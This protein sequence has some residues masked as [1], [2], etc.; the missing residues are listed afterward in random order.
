[1]DA[2]LVAQLAALIQNQNQRANTLHSMPMCCDLNTMCSMGAYKPPVSNSIPETTSSLE[3]YPCS[4]RPPPGLE[5]VMPGPRKGAGPKARQISKSSMSTASSEVEQMDDHEDLESNASGAEGIPAAIPGD[6]S[7]IARSWDSALRELLH[8]VPRLARDA[9]GAPLLTQ[10]INS[11]DMQGLTLLVASLRPQLADLSCDAAGS[12]VVQQIFRSCCELPALRIQ[13]VEGLQGSIQKLTKDKNG[14]LVIQEALESATWEMQMPIMTELNGKVFYCSRHMHGNFV[15]QKVIQML[16]PNSLGF[17]IYELKENAVA[18]ALHIYACRVLQ[19][20]IECCGAATSDLVDIL[21]QPG[22]QLQ[23][24]V[25]DPYSS[26][27]IRSLVVCG[28][29]NHVKTVMKLFSQ[30]VMKFSRNRHASLVLEKCLEVSAFGVKAVSL[31][32]ERLELMNAF[33]STSRSASP[34]LLQIMLD[35][36]GN[37]IVQRV[38]ETCD[39][40]EKEEVKR[41]L[42]MALPKLQSSAAGKHILSAAAKKF[43]FKVHSLAAGH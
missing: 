21:L 31:S 29:P 7:M 10:H 27:V 14:C 25:K 41:L 42:A 24:L 35:R 3:G 6:M 30:D 18:A 19:R 15:M 11:M 26:N 4:L 1:M 8:S 32:Q 22:D 38:I 33:F 40:A 13:L 28:T 12:G 43:G 2:G 9:K 37:Y 17:M 39:G 34:P 20:L 23:R 16:P 5:H 36:F